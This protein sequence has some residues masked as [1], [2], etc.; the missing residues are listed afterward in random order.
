MNRKCTMLISTVLFAAPLWAGDQPANPAPTPNLATP[1]TP[2]ARRAYKIKVLENAIA[3]DK[4]TIANPGGGKLTEVQSKVKI[5]KKNLK[6]DQE[7][8]EKVKG[9]ADMEVYFCSM[10]GREYMKSGTCPHCKQPLTSLFTP[11]SKRPPIN[12]TM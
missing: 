12:P 4:A 2:A 7:V 6:I 11:G 3:E 8:L 9:G 1:E 5:A 10:C